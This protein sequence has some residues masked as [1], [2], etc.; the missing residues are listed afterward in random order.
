MTGTR[1]EALDRISCIHYPVQFKN[2]DKT[3]VQALIDSESKV[4][5]I[6]P[7]FAKQLGL[8]IR[9]MDV[10]A[11]KI[12][13]TILNT[14]E[15]VVAAFSVVDKANWVKFFEKSF[16]VANVSPKVVFGMLFLNLSSVDVDFSG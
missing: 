9:P 5:T 1:E 2:T 15:I 6:H 16:L 11:Q 14:Q 4:N 8:P 3:P 12:D 10:R 7:F 13:G